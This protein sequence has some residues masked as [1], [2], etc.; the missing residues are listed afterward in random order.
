MKT[1]VQQNKFKSEMC[2]SVHLHIM[3]ALAS[4]VGYTNYD[5]NAMKKLLTDMSDNGSPPHL[6]DVHLKP[7]PCPPTVSLSVSC[8]NTEFPYLMF[9]AAAA[10]PKRNESLK[11][12]ILLPVKQRAADV[13]EEATLRGGGGGGEGG[14]GG[15]GGDEGGGAADDD[16]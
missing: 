15:G 16:G 3:T 2:E 14:G 6:K 1:N 7:G 11:P 8:V 12:L 13:A 10:S 4:I 9:L 5:D